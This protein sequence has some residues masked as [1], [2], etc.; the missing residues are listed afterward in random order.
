M[1]SQLP[2][3]ATF[4]AVRSAV[5]GFVAAKQSSVFVG[6]ETAIYPH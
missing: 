2:V 6:G 1:A 4:L 3:A 5:L